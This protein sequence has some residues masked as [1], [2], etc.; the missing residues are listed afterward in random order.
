MNNRNLTAFVVVVVSL[1]SPQIAHA[2][3]SGVMGGG[4]L[5]GFAHPFGGLDH[6]LAMIAVGLW[7][8]Q[9]RGRA[10]WLVPLAFI[11]MMTA[12]GVLAMTTAI[13]PEVELGVA[14]SALVLGVLVA[15]AWRVPL[16]AAVGLVGAFALC[17]GLAHGAEMPQA[18]APGL[19]SLGFILATV[20]LHA[21][22]MMT[23]WFVNNEVGLRLVRVAG[24]AI[25]IVTA[26]MLVGV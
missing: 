6:L 26:V 3:S 19:Y 25:V 20:L 15:A 16:I 13:V 21:S 18:A 24:C 14:G 5:H 11:A 9:M 12:G 23:A 22:G 4:F 7:A 8:A 17:H 1:C 2:H 10:L